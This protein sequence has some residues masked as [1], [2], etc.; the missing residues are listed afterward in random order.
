M[1]GGGLQMD[2]AGSQR[3]S[4]EQEA[5]KEASGQEEGSNRTTLDQSI[6]A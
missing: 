4:P 1:D 3:P 5:A 2:G 6:S